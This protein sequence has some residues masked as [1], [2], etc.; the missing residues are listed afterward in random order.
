MK[1]NIIYLILAL[2]FISSCSKKK[3]FYYPNLKK[4]EEVQNKD[5]IRINSFLNFKEFKSEMWD[6]Y[7]KN[8]TKNPIILLESESSKYY[9]KYTDKYGCMPLIIKLKNVI[10]ISKDSI[11]KWEKY[12]PIE[13]LEYILKTDLLNYGKNNKFADNPNSLTIQLLSPEKESIIDIENN[14]LNLC[15]IYNKIKSQAKDSLE[16]NIEFVELITLKPPATPKDKRS[17]KQK[18]MNKTS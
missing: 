6:F 2:L 8:P 4:F 18:T 17:L 13:N 15:E 14:L 12:Y 1:V 10:G 5:I 7:R 3:E 11:Y 9:I 16:L